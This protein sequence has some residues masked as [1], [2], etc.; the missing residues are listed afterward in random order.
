[1]YILHFIHVKHLLY[2]SSSNYAKNYVHRAAALAQPVKALAAPV[3]EGR[4]LIPATIDLIRI[5]KN[6]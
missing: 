5:R 1:M 4:V 3:A 6:R 2:D